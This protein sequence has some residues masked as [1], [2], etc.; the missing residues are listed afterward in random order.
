MSAEFEDLQIRFTHQEATVEALSAAIARQDGQIS[1][2]RDELE[3]VKRELRE[4][5]ASPFEND[6]ADE[7][8]PPHY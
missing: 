5:Q 1:A 2:M 7:P 6:V 4:L 3:R 8:P